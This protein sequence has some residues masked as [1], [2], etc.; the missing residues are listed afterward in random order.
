MRDDDI[1]VEYFTEEE[2]EKVAEENIGLVHHI[3]G[4]L[5]CTDFDYTELYDVGMFGYAKAIKSFNKQKNIAFSTYA[6]NCI[7]N[8]IIFYMNKE[9][10]H[11]VNDISLNKP[12]TTG[13]QKDLL[14]EEIITEDSIDVNKTERKIINIDN[15][16]YVKDA[17]EKLTDEE[18]KVIC[19]RFGILGFKELKQ[20]ELAKEMKLSQAT[21]SKIER[22]SMKKLSIYL[23][24]YQSHINY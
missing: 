14:L 6:C 9:K 10:K 13:K 12:V 11:I 17:V 24:K 16:N 5:N 15:Y 18:K 1:K 20:K 4:G 22:A 7:R 8:E 21:I 23:L 19:H 3:L 2:A